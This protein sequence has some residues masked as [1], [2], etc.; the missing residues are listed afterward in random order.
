MR[1]RNRFTIYDMMEAKGAFSSNPANADSVDPVEG[2]SLYTGPVKYPRMFYHPE[3]LERVTNPGE[4]TRDPITGAGVVLGRQ[5]EIIWELARDEAD[6]KR[7][8]ADGWHDHPAKAIAAAG[9]EA[10]PISSQQRIDDL[11]AQLHRTQE[12]LAKAKGPGAP[13]TIKRQGSSSAASETL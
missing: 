7:L 12:E 11:E 6:E 13:V 3:G 5:T 4:V 9:G 8:R 1:A 10:P 2:T